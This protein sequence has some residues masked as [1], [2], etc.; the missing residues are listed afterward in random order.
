MKYTPEE[1]QKKNER[2]DFL[3]GR[4]ES[5]RKER[6]EFSAGAGNDDPYFAVLS[7]FEELARNEIMQIDLE[8]AKA[9]IVDPTLN[10]E[11]IISDGDIVDLVISYPDGTT[12]PCTI[13]LVN[14]VEGYSEDVVS[15]NSPIG[16]AIYG[17]AIG[18]E[19][20]CMVGVNT[21]KIKIRGKEQALER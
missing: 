3:K 15:T 2:I 10:D 14:H 12:L 9:E 4:L 16:K 6:A 11:N 18:S 17:Q 19:V 20:E 5:I 21:I 1:V 7:Q 8:L 13:R